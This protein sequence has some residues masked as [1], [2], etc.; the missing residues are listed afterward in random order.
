VSGVGACYGSVAPTSFRGGLVLAQLSYGL[1]LTGVGVKRIV[2]NR[3]GTR[4]GGALDH[5]LPHQ[6]SR[7]EQIA[8]FGRSIGDDVNP[9]IVLWH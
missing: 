2:V 4:F 7:C 1:I 9:Q 3:F 8:L 5:S 6:P